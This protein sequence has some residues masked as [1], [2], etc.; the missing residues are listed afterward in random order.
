MNRI[1]VTVLALQCTACDFQRDPVR[2]QPAET[3]IIVHSLLR[4]GSDTVSVLLEQPRL[5]SGP[6]EARF[7]PV[8]GAAVRISGPGISVVLDEAPTAF[9]A[10]VGADPF[11]PGEAPIKPIGPG[12]YAAVLPGGVRPGEQY[13]LRADIPNSGTIRGEVTIPGTPVISSPV[14]NAQV[15][16]RTRSSDFEP[17]GE[18]AVG[19]VMPAGLGVDV[20]LRPITAFKGGGAAPGTR[21]RLEQ[22]GSLLRAAADVDSARVLIRSPLACSSPGS[23]AR[24][25]APDSL[26]AEVLVTA[27]DTA[28]LRYA[29]A[30]RDEAVGR[31]RAS[32]GITGALGVFGGAATAS[33]S[34]L[35]V[36]RTADSAMLHRF[37]EAQASSH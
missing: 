23:P 30:V 8:S 37:R 12:C 10:C 32:A 4:A 21:C 24:A 5:G 13:E 9:A 19:F 6:G 11:T 1:L 14:A 17:A 20:V 15:P 31:R 7:A 33:R 22:G 28:Y 2:V 27:Y 26:S 3:E 34:I 16:V 29:Y 18:V 36:P 35:L 25:D